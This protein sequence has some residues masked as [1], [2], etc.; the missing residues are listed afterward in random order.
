MSDIFCTVLRLCHTLWSGI[1]DVYTL[2]SVESVWNMMAQ[3]QKPDFLFWLNG[4][5]HLNRRGRQFS[6]LLAAESCASAGSNGSDAGR[7]V[8]RDSVKSTG[9]PLH[10]PVSPSLPRPCVTVRHHISTGLYQQYTSPSNWTFDI[11]TCVNAEHSTYLTA[12]SSF[13]SFSPCSNVIGFCLF[14]ASFSMVAASS[15]KSICVPTNKNGVFWQWC[16]ISG[17]HCKKWKYTWR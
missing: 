9:Y 17:T 7:T 4:W 5:V 12:F 2:T 16:V 6:R 14:L 15:R 8:F 11:H 3:A 1:C 10:S 13:A